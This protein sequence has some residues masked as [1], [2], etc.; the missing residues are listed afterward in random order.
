M[1]SGE[2]GLEGTEHDVYY[3]PAIPA[4]AGGRAHTWYSF[5]AVVLSLGACAC[6]CSG[7][8]VEWSGVEWSGGGGQMWCGA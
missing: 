2:W 3:I 6:P 7:I 5:P 4:A 1:V 8:G